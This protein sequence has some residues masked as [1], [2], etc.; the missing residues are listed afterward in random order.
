MF[1][2]SVHHCMGSIDRFSDRHFAFPKPDWTSS[3]RCAESPREHRLARRLSGSQTVRRV[4]WPKGLLSHWDGAVSQ[5]QGCGAGKFSTAPAPTTGKHSSPGSGS[6]FNVPGS[7]AP[8]P[9]LAKL[10]NSGGS[11]SGP[12]YLDSGKFREAPAPTRDPGQHRSSGS[13]SN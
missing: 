4:R 11:G 13:G 6:D 2:Y 8:A 3:K 5:K 10:P 9:T 7:P 12:K 1:A